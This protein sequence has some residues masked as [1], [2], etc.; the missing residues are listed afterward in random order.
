M[1]SLLAII[2]F[3]ISLNSASFFSSDSFCLASIEFI[4]VLISCI[5]VLISLL[6]DFISF[7]SFLISLRRAAI[8][9]SSSG[10]SFLLFSFFTLFS[11]LS[12]SFALLCALYLLASLSSNNFRLSLTFFLGDG[13]SLFL[14]LVPLPFGQEVSGDSGFFVRVRDTLLLLILEGY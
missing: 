4:L 2:S 12:F 11:S 1:D 13:V 5:I 10:V 6:S 7:M 14:L 8:E 3:L 9:L